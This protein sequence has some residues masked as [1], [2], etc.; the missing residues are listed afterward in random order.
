MSDSIHVRE[1][2]RGT[3]LSD[4]WPLIS[5]VGV[6]GLAAFAIGAGFGDLAMRPVMH[7]YMGMFLIIFAL[8][9]LFDLEGFK[10]G[11]HMYDLLAK[12]AE[13]YGYVYPFIELAL[14]LAFLAF[15]MPTATYIITIAVFAFGAAGVF[16][17]LQEGVDIECPCM[18]N[19]LSVPLSTVTL[20]EDIAMIVMAA[21]LL[22]T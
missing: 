12:K 11:F 14:G 9:K 17:A 6:A 21:V 16:K 5:L 15:F 18:G 7:A 22:A 20:T 3:A 1:E 8:L 19:I 2:G 4:Y 13:P 10:D